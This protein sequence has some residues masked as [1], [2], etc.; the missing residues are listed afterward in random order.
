MKKS[1]LFFK[2]Q[3]AISVHQMKRFASN[4]TL[5]VHKAVALKKLPLA[6]THT[7]IASTFLLTASP[8]LSL[9]HNNC[10]ANFEWLAGKSLREI[11]DS[12]QVLRRKR[13]LAALFQFNPNP[14]ISNS[15]NKLSPSFGGR[16]VAQPSTSNITLT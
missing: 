12:R 11:P 16:A 1:L 5:T 4:F 9:I 13:R 15:P 8:H 2:E 10:P 6:P 3:S 7:S 14:Q